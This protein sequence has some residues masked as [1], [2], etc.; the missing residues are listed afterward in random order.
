MHA[1]IFQLSSRAALLQGVRVVHAVDE[2]IAFLAVRA[3]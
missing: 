1:S 2:E 3:A